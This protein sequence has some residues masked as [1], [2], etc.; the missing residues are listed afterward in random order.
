VVSF[1]EGIGLFLVL[2]IRSSNS[3]SWYWFRADAPPASKKMAIKGQVSDKE[4]L[5]ERITA[6][7]RA[8]KVGTQ[9]S[10]MVKNGLFD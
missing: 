1:R 6:D 7:A 2:S 9:M 10:G 3:H 4:K 5:P 8:E